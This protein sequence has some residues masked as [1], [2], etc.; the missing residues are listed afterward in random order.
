MMPEMTGVESSTRRMV[1]TD[2]GVWHWENLKQPAGLRMNP[3]TRSETISDRIEAHA[4]FSDKGLVGKYSG[5]LAPGTDAMVASREGRIGVDLKSDGSFIAGAEDVFD[6][7]QFLNARLVGDEQDRRRR[8]LKE[9]FTNPKRRDFPDRPQLMFWTDQWGNGFE[10]AEHQKS[11]NATLM[12]VPLQFHR[13]ESGTEIFIPAPML[14]YHNRMAPDGTPPSTMW[15]YSRNEW[16]E[17]ADPGSSWLR[18]SVPRD[19]L[20]L[21]SRRARIDI[22]VSG[23]VGLIEIQGLKNGTV[24][25]LK[26]IV[27][28]V[29]SLSIEIDDPDAL[30]IQGDGAL[31]LGIVA[32]DPS[33]PE[34]T[35]TTSDSAAAKSPSMGINMTAKVNYWRIDSLALQLWAKTDETVKQE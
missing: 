31:D 20:P 5:R 9:L 1:T 30:S 35:H 29:G 24:T 3:F 32:G 7:D 2:F 28:P 18:F 26:K 23:P 27:D 10:F 25:S 22:S 16:Q 15:N 33:R 19:L 8:T 4:T 21:S 6:K 17:R 13:P 11:Q 14:P 34:L 12:C